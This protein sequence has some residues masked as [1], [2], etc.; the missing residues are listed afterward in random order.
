MTLTAPTHRPTPTTRR[1]GYLVAVLINAVL[2]YA[3]NVS[4]GWEAVPFLTADTV[5]VMG[6]VNASI[7]VNLA[8][9]AAYVITDPPWFKAMGTVLTSAVGFLAA[10][11]IW[12]VF[13]FDFDSS[14]FDWALVARIVLGLAIVG[15]AIGVIAGLVALARSAATRSG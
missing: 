5:L 10:V 3:A 4:P 13:P 14:A 2:L 6:L 11:R 15:S 9:N 1:F 8:A 12:Q 7:I